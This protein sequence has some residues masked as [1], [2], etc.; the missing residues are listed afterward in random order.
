MLLLFLGFIAGLGLMLCSASFM[1]QGVLHG[2]G[3][4]LVLFSFHEVWDDRK[5]DVVFLASV[6]GGKEKAS[7]PAS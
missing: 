4:F 2:E 7:L 5:I 3:A 6:A 1:H